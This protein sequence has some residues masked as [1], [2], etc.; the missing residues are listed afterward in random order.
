METISFTPEELV[1]IPSPTPTEQRAFSL[2]EFNRV[3]EKLLAIPPAIAEK[4]QQ[5]TDAK[6]LYSGFAAS[7]QTVLAYASIPPADS[8]NYGRNTFTD[9]TESVNRHIKDLKAYVDTVPV[10]RDNR[11][12]FAIGRLLTKIGLE[13]PVN[14]ERRVTTGTVVDRAWNISYQLAYGI[15]QDL[16]RIRSGIPEKPPFAEHLDGYAEPFDPTRYKSYALNSGSGKLADVIVDMASSGYDES[17]WLKGLGKLLERYLAK[18]PSALALIGKL[19]FPSGL[20]LTTRDSTRFLLRR[21]TKESVKYLILNMDY[22]PDMDTE[23][24]FEFEAPKVA[25]EFDHLETDIKFPYLGSNILT[26]I[27]GI[28]LQLEEMHRLDPS[29]GEWWANLTKEKIFA[30]LSNPKVSQDPYYT[31]VNLLHQYTE[32]VLE[33]DHKTVAN[34]NVLAAY[35]PKL[36]AIREKLR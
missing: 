15:G 12:N 3:S 19:V 33:S 10:F 25:H 32:W 13:L 16:W 29:I 22:V 36:A 17:T 24:V 6:E 30:K 26:E 23:G 1:R 7:V 35:Q 14:W 8:L 2:A 9:S 4:A 28:F 11:D 34:H 20:L 5:G 31:L 18:R 21:S 27:A